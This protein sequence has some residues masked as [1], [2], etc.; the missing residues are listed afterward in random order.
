MKILITGSKGFLG[1][2]F[3]NELVKAGKH[4]ITALVT[5]AGQNCDA[6][7]YIATDLSDSS[8]TDNIPGT[9]DC[10][11][12][13]A[14]SNQYR[15][16]P[17]GAPDMFAV[18]T[19]A[20]ATL[21]DWSSKNGVKKFIYASTGNVYEPRQELLKETYSSSP[22]SYYAASKLSAELLVQSYSG[23]FDT[24]VLRIFSLYG[25][26]QQGMMIP[27]IIQKI[28]NSEPIALA[29][30]AGI[31]LT[32]LFIADAVKM[33]TLIS[34]QSVSSGIYNF[35][36]SQTVSL[37]EIVKILSAKIGISPN[38]NITPNAPAWLAGDGSKLYQSI[39]FK[40]EITLIEGLSLTID[41]HN[42]D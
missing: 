23:I 10:V 6:V 2:A 41:Q 27:G 20:V 33:L 1:S 16:F 31:Y 3:V 29:A 9:A 14:Q 13:L 5:T 40:P 12:Y 38:L 30:S 36:G 8:F 24:I 19:A 17:S 7:K 37:M 26:G 25:P 35:C 18:N 39:N 28:Y 34:E 11:I 22:N 4:E 42:H 32:P 15:N 21:L